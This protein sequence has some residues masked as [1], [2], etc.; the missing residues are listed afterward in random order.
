MRAWWASHSRKILRR[1]SP[2]KLRLEGLEKVCIGTP[3]NELE[4]T[5][6]YDHIKTV[7]SEITLNW[8][9]DHP[10]PPPLETKTKARKKQNTKCLNK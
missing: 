3:P 2:Y 4:R 7:S 10:L 1:L 6:I 9:S 5:L 8:R